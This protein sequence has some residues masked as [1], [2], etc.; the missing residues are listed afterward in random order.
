MILLFMFYLFRKIINCFICEKVFKSIIPRRRERVQENSKRRWFHPK[1]ATGFT[2]RDNSQRS[3]DTLPALWIPD[4]LVHHHLCCS[5]SRY[6]TFHER[7]IQ[8][9]KYRP[10]SRSLAG[11]FRSYFIHN[12]AS[13]FDL[14]G[15]GTSELYCE[16]SCYPPVL[17]GNR[18]LQRLEKINSLQGFSPSVLWNYCCLLCGALSVLWTSNL[19]FSGCIQRKPDITPLRIHPRFCPFLKCAINLYGRRNLTNARIS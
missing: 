16:C 5:R 17:G 13:C 12:W 19:E 9:V 1:T 11:Y 15:N 7:S 4:I 2:T 6:F 3:L 14:S 18:F 10:S 8:Q